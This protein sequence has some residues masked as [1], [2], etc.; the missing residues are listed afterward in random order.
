MRG[1]PRQEGYGKAWGWGTAPG[2]AKRAPK[3]CPDLAL[4]GNSG[5]TDYI[6]GHVVT[7]RR[8][9]GGRL[10]WLQGEWWLVLRYWI[11]G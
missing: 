4:G 2:C 6:L 9:G 3:A 5:L 1:G 10:S 11:A 8:G 7:V